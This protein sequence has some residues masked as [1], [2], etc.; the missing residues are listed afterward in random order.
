MGHETYPCRRDGPPVA[1]RSGVKLVNAAH[2]AGL[3]SALPGFV[4]AP[5]KPGLLREI[6]KES[7]KANPR[8]WTEPR[9]PRQFG[10]CLTG[11]MTGE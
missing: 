4:C 8:N 9:E 3:V 6:R 2:F 11:E 7:E 10:M 5:A 1:V